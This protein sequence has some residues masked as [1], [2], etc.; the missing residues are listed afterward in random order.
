[1]RTC[2]IPNCNRIHKGHGLCNLH[3]QRFKR[4]GD[5]LKH[6]NNLAGQGC[7]NGKGYKEIFI[8]GKQ[9]KEHRYLMEQHLDRKLTRQETI[10]H[11]NG[12][13]T[14]N[15]IENLQIVTQSEHDVITFKKS[16]TTHGMRNCT[17]CKKI[18]PVDNFY[19]HNGVRDGRRSMCKKCD[20]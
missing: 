19:V 9:V 17:K 3:F 8:N 18:L 6:V 12:I 15:R 16:F 13:K 5:P 10:H 7:I 4:Y 14:D 2:T 1:M 11:I 20:P